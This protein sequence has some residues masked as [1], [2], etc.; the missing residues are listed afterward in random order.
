MK[1]NPFFSLTGLKKKKKKREKTVHVGQSSV[2]VVTEGE[3]HYR[4]NSQDP[5][6]NISFH[7]RL[8][9]RLPVY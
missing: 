2:S 6:C 4:L 8:E 9:D 3:I 1:T 5:L 7:F